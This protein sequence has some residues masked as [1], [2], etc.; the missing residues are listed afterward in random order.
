MRDAILM[1]LAVVAFIVGLVWVINKFEEPTST[2]LN[3]IN[4]QLPEGCV[5]KDLGEYGTVDSVVMVDCK[6]RDTTTTTSYDRHGKT[7]ETNTTVKVD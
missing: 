5:F 6:H 1:L 2:Q 7:S 3:K 4:S